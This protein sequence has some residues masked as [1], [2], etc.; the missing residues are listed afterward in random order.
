MHV[1]GIKQPLVD[2]FFI[3]FFC[4]YLKCLKK[5]KVLKIVQPKVLRG[6]EENKMLLKIF[7]LKSLGFHQVFPT[8]SKSVEKNEGQFLISSVCEGMM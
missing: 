5:T 1:T 7:K 2:K 3:C 6:Q 8:L 4:Q